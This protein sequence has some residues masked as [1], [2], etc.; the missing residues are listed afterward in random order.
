[1]TT[2][3]YLMLAFVCLAAG[4][5]G[6][7]RPVR[8]QNRVVRAATVTAAPGE[9][10]RVPITIEAQGN[11]IGVQFS[12]SYDTSLLLNPQL[13]VG[14]DATNNQFFDA[15]LTQTA[16]GRLG[17][18]L[19]LRNPLAQG[20]RQIAIVRFQLAQTSGGQTAAITFVNEPT[21]QRVL[22]ASASLLPADFVPGAVKAAQ[23]FEADVAP[24]PNG[25]NGS[26][27]VADWV[28]VGRFAA[29]LDGLEAGSEF[30]RSDCAPRSTFGNGAITV[31]DWVQAGRYAA[32]LDSLTPAAGPTAP[33]ALAA[34]DL[35]A[36]LK[37]T[38]W[39]RLLR[40]TSPTFGGGRT[41]AVAVELLAQGDENALSFSL[42][43]DARQ[44]HFVSAS[45]G[46][47]A[48]H[49]ALSVN[50]KLAADGQVGVA[51]AL[52]PGRLFEAGMQS[53]LT[54][55]FV[56]VEGGETFAPDVAF[57]D[58]P[59]ARELASVKA[60]ELTA[61][62]MLVSPSLF[63]IPDSNGLAASVVVR[64]GADG[65]QRFESV[66]VFD[67]GRNRFVARPVDVSDENEQV[68]LALFGTGW[69]N[70]AALDAIQVMV[71]A[72]PVEV[73]YAGAQGGQAEMTGFAQLNLRLP[74]ALKGRGK[75]TVQFINAGRSANPV[76]IVIK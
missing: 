75:V 1:M 48:Q 50:S 60:E 69:Q 2:S 8:A 37:P 51:L 63:T 61:D 38:G 40:V 36:L 32:G 72:V 24:R 43:F 17:V 57:S 49:A 46:D 35:P 12:I 28:Q 71:D 65:Q 33:G 45:V 21:R 42:Q 73:L 23:A 55:N 52:P 16:Q 44:W 47:A 29:G 34:T 5:L 64:V 67:S 10:A 41:S 39:P 27:T 30:Q 31:S 13:E 25:S 4:W 3:R 22:D 7:S 70:G 53:L 66:A 9:V 58:W 62:W 11:E 54:V 59:T 18:V 74:P 15:N 19:L 56:A 14:G 68:F 76:K 26:V 20:T 6:L